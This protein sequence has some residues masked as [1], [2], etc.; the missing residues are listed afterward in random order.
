MQR[1]LSRWLSWA[2][3][4]CLLHAALICGIWVLTFRFDRD[5]MPGKLWMGLAVAWLVW[6]GAFGLVRREDRARWLGTLAFGLLLLA[7]TVPTLYTFIVWSI[8][9]VAA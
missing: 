9:G 8:E 5:V 2:G 3:A 7:P 6:F 4:A 1:L